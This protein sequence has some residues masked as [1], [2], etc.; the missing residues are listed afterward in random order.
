MANIKKSFNFRN[1]VQVDDDNLKVSATGLVGI[2]T[3]VPTESLDIRGNIVVSGVSSAVSLQAGVATI[4]TLNPTEIIGAGVSIVSGIVTASSGI[5]TFYGDAR[6]LQGMPTSQWEDTDTGFGVTSIYNTGGNVGIATSNPQFTLQIGSNV[7]LSQNGVGISSAGDIKI[8]GFATATGFVGAL[9]G[10]VTGN[11]TGNLTGNVTGDVTGRIT[12]DVVG[13]VNSLGVSTVSDL[14]VTDLNVDGHTN[15]DNVNIVGLTTFV[16]S[17]GVAGLRARSFAA[18]S[19]AAGEI[20][21]LESPDQSILNGGPMIQLFTNKTPAP[22]NGPGDREEISFYTT[23]Q[24]GAFLQDGSFQLNKNFNVAGI[25]TF[26]GRMIGTATNNVIP[27]LYSNLNDL[28]SAS[29]YHGAFAHVH[30]TG[31][32]Y[33]AH[34]GQWWELVNK[35]SDGRIGTGSEELNVGDIISSGI[36]TATTELNSPLIGV[37]T[38]VPANDI[39]VRKTGNAE[40]QITSDT[41]TAGIT[42]GR[43]V[44]TSNTNNAELR[45]GGGSGFNYSSAQSVDIINYGTGNFNYHLSASNAGNVEGDFHWHRGINN[46]RLMTLTGIG[47]SLGIGITTPSSALHVL[48]AATISGN[49]ILGGNLDVT[50]NAALNVVGQVTGDLTGNVFANSGVSTFKRLDL[51]TSSYYE[52]GEL[53]ASSI[54]IGTT[55]GNFK[56]VVN[57]DADKKFFITDS[58]N[59]GI[60]TTSNNGNALLV[61]GAIAALDPIGIGTDEP[62]AAVD[63]ADAGQATTGLAANRMYM[64]PPKVTNAQRGNL[65]GLVSGAMIYNTNLNKLQ[66]YNGS[67]WETITS[68]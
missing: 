9:T 49:V 4:T 51:D 52:F 19:F 30:A 7:N 22:L 18:A 12:G 38:A 58:G 63:F 15:L 21:I 40:I 65:A 54:G 56:F 16:N 2:G 66:V 28:P 61:N 25:S 44:G 34:A 8:S 3:T 27:F 31:R 68:S 59:V 39:Q 20:R 60:A 57:E 42:V 53:S 33:F 5:I 24:A 26:S 14:R 43:E 36:I 13:N 45:Y 64:I 32:G 1:G 41:G 62:R 23:L 46:A 29:T 10:D 37:G 35:E 48:G 17:S 67:A 6:F 11:V 50:G 55:M 47:G